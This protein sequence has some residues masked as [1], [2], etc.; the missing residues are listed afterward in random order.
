MAGPFIIRGLRRVRQLPIGGQIDHFVSDLTQV[1]RQR[2]S[3]G[4]HCDLCSVS[5]VLGSDIHEGAVARGNYEFTDMGIVKV[6]VEIAN[7]G[8]LG[9]VRTALEDLS[10]SGEAIGGKHDG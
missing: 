4:D 2:S 5:L 1:V 8:A 10:S 9:P 7:K 6:V 3:I